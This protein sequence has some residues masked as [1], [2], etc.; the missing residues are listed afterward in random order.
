MRNK[1]RQLAHKYLPEN[2]RKKVGAAAGK[3]DHGVLDYIKGLIFD[4]FVG[5]YRVD[6]CEFI[7][8]TNITSRHYR[9]CFLNDDWEDG[10]RNL[11]HDFL[12]PTDSVLELGACLGIV[13]CVT[14]KI[15]AD[16]SRHV[17]VEGN[18][19][20][21]PAIH[22]NRELNQAGFLVE[23]AAI[24]HED[25]RDSIFYL[26]P[27]YVVGGTIR[28]Q[29]SLAVRVP[30]YS[31]EELE[32]RYGPFSVLIMD[33][34]GS[35]LD[36]LAASVETLKHY[37]LIII[38]LHDAIIGE[39]NIQRCRDILISSGFQFKKRSYIIEAWEKA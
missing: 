17:V 15:L 25:R 2:I 7:I 13:A 20:C 14:N 29:T 10:E 34:E 18:P 23:N 12:R 9:A 31:L 8:P 28:S 4:I 36:I 24:S 6:G 11:I 30:A 35:E 5:R 27:Q 3:F 26:H 39:S 32:T 33:I 16:K 38:E 37:R 1:I 21:I 22:R 19:F